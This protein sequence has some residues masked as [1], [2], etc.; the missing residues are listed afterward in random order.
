MSGTKALAVL[1][2]VL[3]LALAAPASALLTGN[4]AQATQDRVE[5]VLTT[6]PTDAEDPTETQDAAEAATEQ[7][8]RNTNDVTDDRP[9]PVA[10]AGVH[11]RSG[12][13]PPAAAYGCAA[14]K[15]G[16][17]EAAPCGQVAHDARV[18]AR[19]FDV[20]VTLT[21]TQ[22]PPTPRRVTVVLL[23]DGHEVAERTVRMDVQVTQY[24]MHKYQA[25]CDC[26]AP[27]R[28]QVEVAQDW[29]TDLRL[30]EG[31]VGHTYEVVAYSTTGI[32]DADETLDTPADA[33]GAF[34]A[35]E[36]Q[37]TPAGST[38]AG[39]AGS[40]SAS[41]LALAVAGAVAAVGGGLSVLRRM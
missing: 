26:Y 20:E 23:E 38:P 11:L 34:T 1:L 29:V 3:A 17:G 24:T 30:G 9:A 33:T 8:E 27:S 40:T 12:E 15:A 31:T 16:P 37:A 22:D 19:T 14:A 5:D 10:L 39:A 21:N 13:G 28:T 41:M 6:T 35:H 18:P 4:P 32:V 2:A 36:A 25:A 7:I